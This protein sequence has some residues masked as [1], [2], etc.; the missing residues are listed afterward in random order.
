MDVITWAAMRILNL[1]VT[2]VEQGVVEALSPQIRTI[3]DRLDAITAHVGSLERKVDME[4]A[5]HLRAATTYMRLREFCNARNELISAEAVDD[6][7]AVAKLWLS[8]MFGVEHK[9]EIAIEKMK[10]ALALNPFIVQLLVPSLDFTQN[11]FSNSDIRDA[12]HVPSHGWSIT[13]NKINASLNKP[14]RYKIGWLSKILNDRASD[15]GWCALDAVSLSEEIVIVTWSAGKSD[16]PGCTDRF[17]AAFELSSGKLL[18]VHP[19]SAHLELF[20]AA[21]RFLVMKSQEA[22]E[23]YKFLDMRTGASASSMSE[24]Y[25]EL[26][27]CP[28]S[29]KLHG[30]QGFIK[31]NTSMPL[32]YE[33]QTDRRVLM[34]PF[35][36]GVYFVQVVN[37]WDCHHRVTQI[38]SLSDSFMP[39]QDQDVWS[40][41][42]ESLLRALP[43]PATTDSIYS[44]EN[45]VA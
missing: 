45:F 3:E 15:E 4:L 2:K 38:A 29:A 40:I 10:G 13:V 35:E 11:V 6:R 9:P 24:E 8:I 30:L 18:W 21:P 22:D 16:S 1:V 27:F 20:F 23:C 31:S 19:L 36:K 44:A 37:Q 25:F 28:N 5:E 41:K 33:T 39:D 12:A 17:L 14:S 34:D 43:A 42:C 32:K 26:T 7:S